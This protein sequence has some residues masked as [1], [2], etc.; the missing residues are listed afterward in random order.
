MKKE[1]ELE[2]KKRLFPKCGATNSGRNIDELHLFEESNQ[3]RFSVRYIELLLS[4]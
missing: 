2:E 3:L 1:A 4:L